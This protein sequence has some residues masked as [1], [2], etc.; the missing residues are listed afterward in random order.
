VL[1]EFVL[2]TASY[3]DLVYG[4]FSSLL[5]WPA[6]SFADHVTSSLSQF[7]AAKPRPKPRFG[8]GQDEIASDENNMD[9]NQSCGFQAVTALV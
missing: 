4:T 6:K 1:F 5:T 2:D 7:I 3:S 8:K 9:D